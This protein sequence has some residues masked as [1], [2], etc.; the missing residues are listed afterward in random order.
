MGENIHVG[1]VGSVA[2]SMQVGGSSNTIGSSHG[3]WN[4]DMLAAPKDGTLLCLLIGPEGR[5]NALEDTEAPTPT[6]GFN[7][8]GDTGDD[9]WEF[10][11]WN[12]C[13][14]CFDEGIGV[15]VAWR[16]YPGK[17]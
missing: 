17:D 3:G 14:D 9:I 2:G 7:N 6:I 12:W 8:R 15:P 13:Q 1:P 4:W 11:G 10:A 16:P 5:D